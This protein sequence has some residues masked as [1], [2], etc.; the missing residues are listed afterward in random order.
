MSMKPEEPKGTENIPMRWASDAIAAL[1][2]ELDIPFLALN[3]G[4][5]FRGLLDS[6]VN[7]LGNRDPQILLSLH[8]ESAVAIATGYAK[9]TEKPMGVVLHSNVP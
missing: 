6:L 5:S 1:L 9:V 3:P 7:Y 4:A 8:E 2:R